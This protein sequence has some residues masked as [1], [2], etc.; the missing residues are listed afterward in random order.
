MLLVSHCLADKLN[1]HTQWP[2]EWKASAVNTS[3]ATA[4]GLHLDAFW[5]MNSWGVCGVA[6]VEVNSHINQSG[7]SLQQ[8]MQKSPCSEPS[9]PVIVDPNQQCPFHPNHQFH[10]FPHSLLIFLFRMQQSKARNG[11][12]Y[13]LTTDLELRAMIL[14]KQMESS[15]N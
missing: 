12:I 10:S 15:T 14:V 11:N 9:K 6:T 8:G 5:L 3:F 13:M 2:M 7:E 4:K 1:W